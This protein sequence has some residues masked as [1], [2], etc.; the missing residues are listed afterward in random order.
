MLGKT[1]IVEKQI[2]WAVRDGIA[3]P[4]NNV[5][6]RQPVGDWKGQAYRTAYTTTLD[7]NLFEPLC[8]DG[9]CEFLAGDG[10]ELAEKMQALYSSSALACNFTHA[11]RLRHRPDILTNALED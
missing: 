9:R 11:L 6:Q 7:A 10:S 5:R 1:Y 2:L 8:E 4:V 3:P